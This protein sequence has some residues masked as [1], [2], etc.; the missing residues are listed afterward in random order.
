MLTQSDLERRRMFITATDVPCI[1]GV[2]KYKN[3]YDVYVEKTQSLQPWDGNNATEAGNLLEPA[4]LAWASKKLGSINPGEWRVHENGI[5]AATLDGILPNGEVVECKSHGICGPTNW[6]DWG[7]EGTD[8]IPDVYALQVQ[9]QMLVTG[10]ART[11]VPALI[12]GRGFVLY[13]MEKNEDIH[14]LI[15]DITN[16]FWNRVQDRNPP[17]GTPHLE[18]MKRMDRVAGKAITIDDSLAIQYLR[19]CEDA[20][21]AND[22]KEA[23]QEA[24]LAAIGDAEIGKWHGGEF[25]YKQQTRKAYQVEAGTFRVLRSKR[26]KELA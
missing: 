26:Q 16:R 19:A 5:L 9:T 22:A 8:D 23:A 15:M 18:I 13:T 21:E 3:A 17:E 6:D 14:E 7:K 11:W 20:K 24:L 2:N 1:I 25:T 10:A 4:I 12:G